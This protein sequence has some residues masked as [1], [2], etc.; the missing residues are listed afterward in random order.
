MAG[1]INREFF[2]DQ[3][4]ARLFD[5]KLKQ[6]QVDGLT[7]ILNTWEEGYA[8]RDDRWLAYM[9]ATA[10]HE[11]ARRM[12]PITEFGDRGYFTRMYDPPPAG[13]RPK[14]AKQLGNTH[15]GDGPMFC[16]R[17]FVQLT[18][19]SNYTDWKNR[20]NVDLVGHP[21]LALELDV[22][23]RVL[24]EGM[25]RGTFTSRKLGDYF[26]DS[27]SDWV[28]ARRIINKL[29]RADEIAT[30]GQ[31]FYSAISYTT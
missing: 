21:E 9:L 5:G 24:F 11:V 8:T 27:K 2:F 14:V 15:P 23:T 28:N 1:K 31:K 12:Q 19:R 7:H 30:Y 20:L 6:P 17:G 16:G 29:D 3:V 26:D 4:K 22:A 10:Y 25:I 18:G 13:K